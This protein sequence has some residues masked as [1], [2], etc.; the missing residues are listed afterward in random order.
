M[1]D[2]NLPLVLLVRK[3]T[4]HLSCVLPLKI[5]LLWKSQSCKRK[6]MIFIVKCTQFDSR[7]VLEKYGSGKN[8]LVYLSNILIWSVFLSFYF[9]LCNKETNFKGILP[10]CFYCSVKTSG[11]TGT[12]YS[13]ITQLFRHAQIG[14]HQRYPIK[15]SDKIKFQKLN[16][17]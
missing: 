12:W 7:Q 17:K 3:H 2:V 9:C 4:F 6:I 5:H 11:H 1:L 14:N 15:K 8:N 16:L 13:F 10:V